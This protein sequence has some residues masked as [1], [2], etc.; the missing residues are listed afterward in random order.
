MARKKQKDV[1][2]VVGDFLHETGLDQELREVGAEFLRTGI[3]A[4]REEIRAASN[5][6]PPPQQE[7]TYSYRFIPRQE[8]TYTPPREP[9]PDPNDPYV[10]LK[11]PRDMATDE[12]EAV[13]RRR[14]M[15]LHPDRSGDDKEFKRQW[16]AWE[17]IKKERG[18]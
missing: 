18:I 2:K 4:V 1:L 3:N 9:Q 15:N 14:A 13:M 12:L 17:Q 6:L 5:P 11:L 7:P 8:P 16:A 10:I